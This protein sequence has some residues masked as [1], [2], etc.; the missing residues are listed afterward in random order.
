MML[1]ENIFPILGVFL[2]TAL[3]LAPFPAVYRAVRVGSL[4]T[5]NVIPAAVMCLSTI[6][7]VMYSLSVPNPYIFAANVPGTIASAYYVVATLPLLSGSVRER[8]SV[9][10]I[11]VVGTTIKLALWG[12][13]IFSAMSSEDRS[14]LLGGYASLI[15]VILFASPLSTIREVIATGSAVSIYA[16]LTLT[17]ITNCGTWTFYGWFIVHDVWVYGPNGAG[18]T[19]GLIQMVLK[20]IYR[21]KDEATRTL[22]ARTSPE[23]WDDN[24]STENDCR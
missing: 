21:G 13:V 5:F 18:L 12:Y 14:T 2:S 17:Q 11:I 7:W 8:A 6:S 4:G 22:R 23:A 20:L 24:I 16:P 10:L 1:S 15:C 3:Y 19:L 9:Q